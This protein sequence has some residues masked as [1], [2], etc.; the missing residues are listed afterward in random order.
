[1]KT[2]QSITAA[3][4]LTTAMSWGMSAEAATNLG[5]GTTAGLTGLSANAGDPSSP[6]MSSGAN[7]NVDANL[8]LREGVG[9]KAGVKGSS[10]GKATLSGKAGNSAAE[11]DSGATVNM[12][13]NAGM[14]GPL[15]NAAGNAGASGAVTTTP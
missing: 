4:F 10:K 11:S 7:G 12:G 2:R 14:K 15:A 3:I 13:G 5:I 9:N 8:K 1:M 6:A